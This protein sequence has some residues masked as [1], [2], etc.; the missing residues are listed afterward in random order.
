[1]LSYRGRHKAWTAA[2]RQ[3][4]RY[5]SILY[6]ENYLSTTYF[7]YK[8]SAIWSMNKYLEHLIN[9]IPISYIIWEISNGVK[10]YTLACLIVSDKKIA[11]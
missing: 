6:K 2:M 9:A 10:L 3:I 7:F 11:N 5:M 1:M 8:T 4:I